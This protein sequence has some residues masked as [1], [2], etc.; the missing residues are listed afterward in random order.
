M[1]HAH[2]PPFV[3]HWFDSL[4]DLP[5][6]GAIPDPATAAVFSTDMIN[7]FVHEGPLSSDR[8]HALA[9]PV[10]SLFER[11]WQ[12]GVKDFVLTQDTHSPDTPEFLSY[13]PHAIA[14]TAESQMIPELAELPFAS[15]FNVMPKNSLHPAINT[16]FNTWLGEHTDLRTAIVVGNC[17]DLCIYQLAMHLRMWANAFDIQGFRVI[18]PANCV[19]TFDI[20]ESPDAEPGSPHP[21]EFFHQTFLYHMASNGVQIVR[22]IS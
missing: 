22:S 20:P 19:D 5:I 14:G 16:R 4:A 9:A 12:H 2:I 11:S 17:T 10:A 6:A 3:A 7:G 1:T 13:P 18:V 15:I 21:A 8:V